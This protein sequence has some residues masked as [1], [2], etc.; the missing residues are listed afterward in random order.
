M[1]MASKEQSEKSNLVT[2]PS[3]HL[4]CNALHDYLI[5]LVGSTCKGLYEINVQAIGKFLDA[6]SMIA[7]MK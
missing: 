3:I 4:K 5:L 2:S 6:Y 7:N 1:V